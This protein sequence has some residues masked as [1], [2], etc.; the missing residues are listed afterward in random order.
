MSGW[1]F[2]SLAFT[3]FF[4]SG[5]C[6]LLHQQTDVVHDALL[7][8]L[9]GRLSASLADVQAYVSLRRAV[10]GRNRVVLADAPDNGR[11]VVRRLLYCSD[12]FRLVLKQSSPL[13]SEQSLVHEFRLAR[14]GG[15]VP[16]TMGLRCSSLLDQVDGEPAVTTFLTEDAGHGALDRARHLSPTACVTQRTAIVAGCLSGSVA[17]PISFPLPG[18]RHLQAVP[19]VLL[20]ET[21]SKMT[22]GVVDSGPVLPV[23]GT[24][25]EVGTADRDEA[26]GNSKSLPT[27][28]VSNPSCLDAD[29]ADEAA[30]VEH[31]DND[32]LS[33][34]SDTFDTLATYAPALL[35]TDEEETLSHPLPL[36]EAFGGWEE[37]FGWPST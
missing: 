2:I 7:S 3:W 33:F 37:G 27:G 29:L 34:F 15:S 21:T 4:L 35:P 14:S 28:G 19:Q 5:L 25:K 24:A 17:A 30:A 12:R 18:L 36:S 20:D 23:P 26:V 8:A 13:S 1:C 9:G 16:C 10:Y 32:D 11:R 6:S 31:A 22:T